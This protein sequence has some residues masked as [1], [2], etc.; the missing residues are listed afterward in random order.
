MAETHLSEILR[1]GDLDRRIQILGLTYD[2]VKGEGRRTYSSI[3]SV[4][5]ARE[6]AG[7]GEEEK[8]GTIT[9]VKTVLFTI[10]YNSQF[11]TQTKKYEALQLSEVV[12]DPV[13]LRD[14]ANQIIYDLQGNPLIDLEASGLTKT[15]DILHIEEVGRRVGHVITAQLWR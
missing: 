6:D 5:A 4:R 15:Y 2:K 3:M 13:Y 14:L 11:S 9:E 7:G 1:G 10:R 8:S 12:N